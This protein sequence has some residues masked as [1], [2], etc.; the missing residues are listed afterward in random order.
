M[1]GR[2]QLFDNRHA[3]NILISRED[4][5]AL[6]REAEA[7]RVEQPGFSVGDLVRGYIQAGLGKRAPARRSDPRAVRIRQLRAIARSAL[8]VARELGETA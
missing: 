4:Y 7:Q 3:L 1:R 6:R 2:P 8:E 5:Q